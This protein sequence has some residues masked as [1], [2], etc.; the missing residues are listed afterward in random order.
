[1]HDTK[2]R[3]LLGLALALLAVVACHD[4]DAAYQAC[5]DS[6]NCPDTSAPPITRPG[7]F[8]DAE[9][10]LDTN[11]GTREAPFQTLTAALASPQPLP[12]FYLA[13]GDYTN[14]PALRVERAVSLH[15]GYTGLKGDWKPSASY[16]VIHGG[17]IGLTVTGLGEDSGVTLEWLDILT[18][19]SF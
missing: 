8:V 13:R 4:F 17:P 18:S 7:I 2:R 11:P 19:S 6:G 15:G 14:E 10:G 1:M 5:K 3:I 9:S 16:S 12:D